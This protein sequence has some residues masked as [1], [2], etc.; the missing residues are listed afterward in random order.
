MT[1]L[2]LA[3]VNNLKFVCDEKFIIG[4]LIV[5]L[6]LLMQFRKKSFDHNKRI[7]TVP[8]GCVSDIQIK[9]LQLSDA[10]RT[11]SLLIYKSK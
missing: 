4:N 9:G 11:D 5:V 7:R 10:A 8:S 6:S 3:Q 1:L 2:V